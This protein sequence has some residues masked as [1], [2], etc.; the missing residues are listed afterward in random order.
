MVDTGFDTSYCIICVWTIPCL[1]LLV[2]KTLPLPVFNNRSNNGIWLMKNV[3]VKNR[4][5]KIL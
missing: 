5:L 2:K 3:S 1:V 4:C